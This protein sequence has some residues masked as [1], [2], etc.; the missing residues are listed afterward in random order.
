M[1]IIQTASK[2]GYKHHNIGYEI[3]RIDELTLSSPFKQ[4]EYLFIQKWLREKH[5]ILVYVDP[6]SHHYFQYHIVTNDDEII[7]SKKL[8][9]WDKILELGLQKALTLLNNKQ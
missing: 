4:I 3:K 2:L 6:K 8:N 7:G 9:N 5:D 1:N